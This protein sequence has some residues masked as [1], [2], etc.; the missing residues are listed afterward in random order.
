MVAGLVV[1]IIVFIE[2]GEED[3][4]GV[5]LLYCGCDCDWGLE[6]FRCDGS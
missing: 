2:K 6:R 4:R 3:R 1:V 5:R